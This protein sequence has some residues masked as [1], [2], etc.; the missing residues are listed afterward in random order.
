MLA[1][2]LGKSG[3]RNNDRSRHR[4]PR[5]I[6]GSHRLSPPQ[7]V[8]KTKVERVPSNQSNKGN[9]V[10]SGKLYWQSTRSNSACESVL[11]APSKD[12]A[13]WHSQPRRVNHLRSVADSFPIPPANRTVVGLPL[14]AFSLFGR[15]AIHSLCLG[16]CL[17]RVSPTHCG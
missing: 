3:I 7:S 14:I 5:S 12:A 9:A 8:E 11:Q 10:R 4:L 6:T 17:T 16:N 1:S 13:N 2:A 15:E